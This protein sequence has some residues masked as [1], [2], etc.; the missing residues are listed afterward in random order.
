MEGEPRVLALPRGLR[1][2]LLRAAAAALPR[3]AC[4]LLV[5]R[6]SGGTVRVERAIDAANVASDARSEFA[7]D[8][9]AV[10]AAYLAAEGEGATVVGTWHSH[11]AGRAEP[12]AADAGGLW[13]EHVALIVAPRDARPVRAFRAGW[14]APVELAVIAGAGDRASARGLSSPASGIGLPPAR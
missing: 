1:E 3:E 11:P 7:I 10:V 2:Q 9:G 6:R 4:G 12:S 8:P 5:G 14:S 13:P